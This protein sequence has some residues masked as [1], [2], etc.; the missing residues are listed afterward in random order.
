MRVCVDKDT[1]VRLKPSG[2]IGG[3][4]I[5]A[6]FINVR[7]LNLIVEANRLFNVVHHSSSSTNPRGKYWASALSG[8]PVVRL[9]YLRECT[10]CMHTVLTNMLP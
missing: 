8:T 4:Y 10:C 1:G 3:E 2:V 7:T 6:T 5:N 9:Q